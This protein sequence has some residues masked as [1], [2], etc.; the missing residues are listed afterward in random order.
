MKKGLNPVEILPQSPS[1]RVALAIAEICPKAIFCTFHPTADGRKIPYNRNGRGVSDQTPK[2]DLYTAEQML[3]STEPEGHYWGLY[4]HEPVYDCFNTSLLTILDVDMKRTS[5]STDIRITKLAKWA[6]DNGHLTERSYS[7]KGRHVIFLAP[8]C[9]APPKY[10]LTDHQEIEVF[11]QPNSPKKSVM[12]TGDMLSQ[13]HINEVEVDLLNVLDGLGIKHEPEPEQKKTQP[14]IPVNYSTPS[15]EQQKARQALNFISPD[16]DYDEWIAIGQAL[17]TEF[18]DAGLSMWQD[19]SSQGQ[20]YQGDKDIDSHWRSFHAGK[21]VSMG[22]LYHM[23]KQGGYVPPTPTAERRTAVEDFMQRNTERNTEPKTFIDAMPDAPQ[24]GWEEFPYDLDHLPAIRYMLDGF[25]AHGFWVIAGQPGVGKTTVLMSLMITIMGQ[26]LEGSDVTAST[27]RKT[28]LV[29]E[30]AE[31]V[32]RGLYGY[33]KHF[34]IDPKL[35]TDNIILIRAKRSTLPDLLTLEHNINR[36]TAADGTR[37]WLILDTANATLEM[38]NENDNS[39]VGAYMNG[40]KQTIYT[41]MDTPI[42]IVTHLNKQVAKTD[43]D[44]M[45]RGASAWTGDATGTAVIFTDDEGRRYMRLIKRRYEP[46]F[47]EIEFTTHTFTALATTKDGDMAETICRVMVPTISSAELRQQRIN[48][49][50]QDTKQQRAQDK[51]DE[52]CHY[53]QSQINAH[54]QGVVIR[55]GR[56]APR[57]PPSDMVHCYKLEMADVFAAI[58]GSSRGDVK[59]AVI[60]AIMRRF[61]PDSSAN[62]WV[63]LGV[64]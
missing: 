48:D 62:E 19:W 18:Q 49:Q 40:L 29:T 52:A 46:M 32:Q 16:I 31:Q 39:E 28:I 25:F 5:S 12:L 35:I 21:G 55:R 11:G 6:K 14:L 37:P 59:A 34:R 41:Q 56:T 8:R 15:D 50:Q 13:D 51:A 44:A 42:S 64:Q 17:H 10:K 27:R 36:H 9:D 2:E 22:T 58:P 26:H 45:A 7:Q 24:D 4:M 3:Q 47:E 1:K 23:A 53:V 43:S 61:A 63:R 57:T 30:D 60:E 54:P 38:E 20:K 33:A